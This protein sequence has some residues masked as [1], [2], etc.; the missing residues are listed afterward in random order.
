MR[1]LQA[2]TPSPALTWGCSRCGRQDTSP[3]ADTDEAQRR[4]IRNCDEESNGA[5]YLHEHPKLKRCPWSQVQAED[6]VAVSRWS[7]WRTLQLWPY[8]GA[9]ADQPAPVV[10]EISICEATAREMADE[11]SRTDPPPD[12]KK[13]APKGRGGR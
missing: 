10:A 9:G 8:P 1:V 4:A 12:V 2:R 5:F 11:W 6:E 7:L 13:K 3:Q